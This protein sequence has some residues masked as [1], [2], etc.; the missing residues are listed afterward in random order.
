[1]DGHVRFWLAAVETVT[2]CAS[3]LRGDASETAAVYAVSLHATVTEIFAGCLALA[4]A[5]RPAG[6]PILVRAIYEAF[7]DLDNLLRD[8]NY[9]KYMEAANLKAILKLLE[10]GQTNPLFAGLNDLHNVEG[11]RKEYSAELSALKDDGFEPLKFLSR[12][13]RVNREDEYRTIYAV[14]CLD[15]HNNLAALADRHIEHDQD[16]SVSVVSFFVGDDAV[17]TLR[18]LDLAANLFVDAAVMIH[19]AFSTGSAEITSLRTQQAAAHAA[20]VAELTGGRHPC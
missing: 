6:I 7:V 15:A 5:D 10:Q 16:G 13:K 4:N 2:R 19:E 20:I 9:Y 14:Y 3:Q 1:M 11:Y 8:A 18:R 12:C 17:M